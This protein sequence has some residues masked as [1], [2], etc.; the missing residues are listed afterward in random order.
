MSRLILS[1]NFGKMNTD[2]SIHRFGW[3]NA[4]YLHGLS[5]L[6]LNARHALAMGVPYEAFAKGE[7]SA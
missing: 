1:L 2:F 5:L 7:H 6:S 4:S 3:T